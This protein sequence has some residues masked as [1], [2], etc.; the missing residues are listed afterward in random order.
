MAKNKT[1][2]RPKIKRKP[3]LVKQEKGTVTILCPFCDDPHPIMT[4]ELAFCGT[5][6][7]LQAV[8]TV[9]SGKAI[10]CLVCDQVGG[11]LIKWGEGYRHA[12]NCMPGTNYY[13]EKITSFS[14]TAK[15]VYLLPDKFTQWWA[16]AFHRT[17][18][19]LRNVNK[20][21]SVSD[22]VVGYRWRKVK[23]DVKA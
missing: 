23:V 14:R 22:E 18:E 19:A 10:K 6:L 8:Q 11:Q 3:A 20:D 16:S 2:V 7:E 1:H 5:A 21:G 15:I 12:Q 17:P 9:F 13:E 4:H